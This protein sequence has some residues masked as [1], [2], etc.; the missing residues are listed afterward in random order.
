MDATT[1][2]FILLVMRNYTPGEVRTAVLAAIDGAVEDM[3]PQL[4]AAV[5][6]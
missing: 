4:L 6:E 2:E 3:L 5:G 1:R